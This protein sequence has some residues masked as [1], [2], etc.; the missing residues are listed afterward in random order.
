MLE[1]S[2]FASPQRT[3]AVVLTA[4]FQGTKGEGAVGTADLRIVTAPGPLVPQPMRRT[5]V[6][7]AL[8]RNRLAARH[9]DRAPGSG[10]T[11]TA[12]RNSIDPVEDPLAAV[13]RTHW[14]VVWTTGHDVGEGSEGSAKDARRRIREVIPKGCSVIAPMLPG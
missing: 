2:T 12:P 3:R 11:P 4:S 5:G 13:A 1:E 14:A 9:Q 8:M 10:T 7:S 6:L